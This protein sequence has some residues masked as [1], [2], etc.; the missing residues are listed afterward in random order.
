M[1]FN[2]IGCVDANELKAARKIKKKSKPI[3]YVLWVFFLK[4]KKRLKMNE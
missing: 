2:Y 4:S 3:M 1:K